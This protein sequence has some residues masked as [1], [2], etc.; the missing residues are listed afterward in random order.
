MTRS[1][2]YDSETDFLNRSEY[3]AR[4]AEANAVEGLENE[5]MSPDEKAANFVRKIELRESAL[6]FTDE[7]LKRPNAPPAT[8]PK[9]LQ[10]LAKDYLELGV[11][12]ASLGRAG[13]LNLAC[14]YYAQSVLCYAELYRMYM[15]AG[16]SEKIRD[17]DIVYWLA[18]AYQ[19]L[20]DL[21][22]TVSNYRIDEF[23]TAAAFQEEYHGSGTESSFRD[24][25][26]YFSA[27]A[28]HKLI[29]E[30]EK[31]GNL[32]VELTEYFESAVNNYLLVRDSG[33]KSAYREDAKG[34]LIWLKSQCE[35]FVALYP[36]KQYLLQLF[37]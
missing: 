20:G 19:H 30:F 27:I 21:T 16:D 2:F 12:Y 8:V 11:F 34:A 14:Q 6:R 29:I 31:T 10:L 15:I 36:E 24:H 28:S 13:D 1:I 3:A 22:S 33:L 37:K 9:L 35:S 5:S 26:R 32:P 7:N 25:S 23:G 4:V 18:A 17:M